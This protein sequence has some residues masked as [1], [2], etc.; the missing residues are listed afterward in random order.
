MEATGF[1]ANED[2]RVFR[3]VCFA[4]EILYR[5]VPRRRD[6]GETINSFEDA[7]VRNVFLPAMKIVS[8]LRKV[9]DERHTD[10]TNRFN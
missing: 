9:T 5:D 10:A 6:V 3:Q 8:V 7:A 4:I 1:I 2:R